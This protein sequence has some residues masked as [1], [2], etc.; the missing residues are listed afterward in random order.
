[1]DKEVL[2]KVQQA[3]EAIKIPF[4]RSM[5]V[6]RG[7]PDDFSPWTCGLSPSALYNCSLSCRKKTGVKTPEVKWMSIKRWVTSTPEGVVLPPGVFLSIKRK[8]EFVPM[9]NPHFSKKE[10]I[11]LMFPYG[12]VW[13]QRSPD[14]PIDEDWM[15]GASGGRTVFESL[16]MKDAAHPIP[17]YFH[18]CHKYMVENPDQVGIHLKRKRRSDP[19]TEGP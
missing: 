16:M 15:W 14:V 6:F 9:P 17:D 4:F 2:E 12:N 7:V 8:E 11:L 10:F 5:H 1:M 13:S 19:P 18:S 3:V